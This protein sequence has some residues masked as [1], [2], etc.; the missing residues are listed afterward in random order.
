MG[1][2][3]EDGMMGVH[4]RLEA[5]FH[6]HQVA[7]LDRD[8]ARARAELSAYRELLAAHVEDEEAH[9]L[10][11]YAA[12]GG[13]GTDAPVR[14]F[15]GEHRNLLA[16]TAEFDE[17]VAALVATPDDRALLVLFDRE[18]TFKNLVMHHDLR[19]RRMLY[20][21]LAARLATDEQ[22]AVL[23]SARSIAAG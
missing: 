3:L 8:F 5:G 15:L 6:A 13:D 17:R 21:F 1:S 7:L 16:F 18:A 12:A 9:V 23:A 22:L 10:P 2:V 20:P 19:E 11:R 14:L 4:D